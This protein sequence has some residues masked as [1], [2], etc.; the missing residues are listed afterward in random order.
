MGFEEKTHFTLDK[1][2][3]VRCRKC[4][5]TCAGMVLQPDPEGVKGFEAYA[6]AYENGLALEREACTC[7]NS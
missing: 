6:Q 3:C 7:W 5:N 1:T 2:K 4:V